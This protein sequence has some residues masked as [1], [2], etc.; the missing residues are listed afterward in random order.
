MVNGTLTVLPVTDWD[1]RHLSSTCVEHS[2]INVA[3]EI[4]R[5]SQVLNKRGEVWSLKKKNLIYFY[6]TLG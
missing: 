2:K 5:G 4:L 1:T 6:F 3:L